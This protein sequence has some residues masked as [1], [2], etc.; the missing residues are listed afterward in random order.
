MA[1]ANKPEPEKSYVTPSLITHAEKTFEIAKRKT[2]LKK[3]NEYQPLTDSKPTIPSY[4]STAPVQTAERLPGQ[5]SDKHV[6]FV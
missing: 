5:L 1:K 3:T 6:S 2:I 4:T